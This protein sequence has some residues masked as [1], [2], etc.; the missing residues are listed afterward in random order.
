[1][2]LRC[3]NRNGPFSQIRPH[4]LTKQFWAFLIRLRLVGTLHEHRGVT[5]K[6][7]ILFYID[8][9]KS[10]HNTKHTSYIILVEFHF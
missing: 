2:F 4:M 1:M 6:S 7:N 10:K 8:V 3:F 5:V 9:I